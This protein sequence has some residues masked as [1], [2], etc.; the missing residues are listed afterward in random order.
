MLRQRIITGTILAVL[1]LLVIF[2]TP[3]VVF[4]ALSTLLILFAAFEFSRLIG[5]KKNIARLT[6]V[7]MIALFTF[8]FWLLPIKPVLWLTLLWWCLACLLIVTYPK[9][10]FL[11]GKRTE[12]KAVM[13]VLALIPAWLAVNAIRG[14]QHG[15]LILFLLLLLVWSADIGAYF[16]G[17]YLGKHHLLP[18]VSPKKTIEGL[19]GGLG[20]SLLIITIV[21][22]IAKSSISE[23]ATMILL[24]TITVLF[25]VAGDLFESMLKREMG[26]K[27]SGNYLPGHGGLLDRIDSLTAAAPLFLLGL[28]LIS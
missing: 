25:S 8:L 21:G 12:M 23:W 14:M 1:T 9:T 15:S 20:L 16:I 5:L 2:F 17:K 24:T 28:W 7:I 3:F 26:I 18:K 11:W 10:A 4:S 19:F 27:D 13:G 22:L 6:Y